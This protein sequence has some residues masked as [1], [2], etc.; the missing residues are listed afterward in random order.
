LEAVK[1]MMEAGYQIMDHPADLRFRV[2]APDSEALFRQAARALTETLFP[3]VQATSLTSGEAVP[4]EI[5]LDGLDPDDLLVR[6][7]GELLFQ[8]ETRRLIPQTIYFTK[9]DGEQL[10]ASC[11][12]GP[13]GTPDCE[14]KAVT[15]HQS[16]I[17]ETEQG[18]EATL[19]F[20]V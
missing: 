13:V 11:T 10:R 7:L 18:L 5:T 4:M 6:W 8:A 15:Y 14:I 19:L 16:G 3:G 2:W 20:D 9:L 17:R 1:V 12:M